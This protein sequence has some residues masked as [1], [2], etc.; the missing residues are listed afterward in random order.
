[1]NVISFLDSNIK[2]LREMMANP[3]N[4][5]ALADS[6]EYLKYIRTNGRS[7]NDPDYKSEDE[8]EHVGEGEP[9]SS[10]GSAADASKKKRKRG[11]SKEKRNR[12]PHAFNVYCK[13]QRDI[14]RAAHPEMSFGMQGK[15]LAAQ[16]KS[17]SDSERSVSKD[18][19]VFATVKI[20]YT[21][22][23]WRLC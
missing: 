2:A 20:E 18:L 15:T 17:L 21:L 19:L 11:D 3:A 4:K 14:L 5:A 6:E 13:E 7:L 12:V 1:M 10:T 16:W 22:C 8:H 9:S 23:I